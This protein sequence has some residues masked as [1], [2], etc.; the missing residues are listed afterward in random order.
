M[1]E[2]DTG[3]EAGKQETGMEDGEE[4]GQLVYIVLL[5]W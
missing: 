4:R 1:R 5:P 3:V 2:E